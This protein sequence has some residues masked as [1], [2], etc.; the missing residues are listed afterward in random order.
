MSSSDDAFVEAVARFRNP[1]TELEL[2]LIKENERLRAGIAKIV[3]ILP[4]A[5]SNLSPI[6]VVTMSPH[7]LIKHVHEL[8]GTGD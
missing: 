1:K 4:P 8:L 5:F 3:E 6:E 7:T 2:Q